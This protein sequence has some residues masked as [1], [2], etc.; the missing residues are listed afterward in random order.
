MANIVLGLLYGDEG[1]GQVTDYFAERYSSVAFGLP[2]IVRFSGGQ[3]AGHTVHRD[4]KRHTFSSYGSGGLIGC[5]T[6]I[7][8]HCTV[9]MPNLLR[10]AGSLDDLNPHHRM[11][12]HPLANLTTPYDIAYNRMSERLRGNA[13]HGSCGL[14][15]G[16]T[17]GRNE[18][19]GA[20]LFMVDTL[21]TTVFLRK[22]GNVADYY[23]AK[24]QGMGR[25]KLIFDEEL[26]KLDSMV[27]YVSACCTSYDP[28]HIAIRG[29]EFLYQKPH[30]IFEGS[31][32][33]LLDMDHGVFPYVTRTSTTSKN[34][35]EVCRKLNVNYIN[36]SY[37]SRSY[38]TRHGNDGVIGT[39]IPGFTDESNPDNDWQGKIRAYPLDFKLMR[40]AIEIDKSYHERDYG[41]NLFMMHMDGV[42][43][44]KGFDISKELVE[45]N[46]VDC[47]YFSTGKDAKSIAGPNHVFH[48]KLY[49]HQLYNPS[50][51]RTGV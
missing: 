11:I 21:N 37:V 50:D 24:L 5:P 26:H 17:I 49:G 1:K 12:I 29:Y 28:A 15:V 44:S 36:I 30:L 3:Q 33:I 4:G 23:L 14:G 31:Q 20:K 25:E 51:S 47:I 35:L 32:G 34:A 8:E 40:Y 2:I 10:E 39:A 27:D 9:Y 22:L 48:D 13:H 19:P 45:T 38:I 7:T 16:A 42:H 46:Y 43:Q 6:Y 18:E 41:K